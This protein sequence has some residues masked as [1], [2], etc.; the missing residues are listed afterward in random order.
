MNPVQQSID[1][2]LILALSTALSA[3]VVEAI[4]VKDGKPLSQKIQFWLRLFIVFYPAIVCALVVT[5][6]QIFQIGFF[7]YLSFYWSAAYGLIAML[8][9]TNLR[10]VKIMEKIF[11]LFDKNK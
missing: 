1:F 5:V 2:M 10:Q 7:E 6:G 4:I 9:A 3:E 11:S 8:A